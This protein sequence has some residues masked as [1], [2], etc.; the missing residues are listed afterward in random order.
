MRLP[1]CSLTCL[2]LVPPS[3][4]GEVQ[5][6]SIVLRPRHYVHPQN[7]TDFFCGLQPELDAGRLLAELSSPYILQ[8]LDNTEDPD[9]RYRTTVQD[10]AFLT[11][12]SA[13]HMT[14]SPCNASCNALFALLL[15]PPTGTCYTGVFSDAEILGKDHIVLSSE[16][17]G[18]L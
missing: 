5:H 15:V 10:I 18:I 12:T 6:I 17:A 7:R 13:I 1:V 8:L 2:L 14:P 9:T 4:L 3:C 16:Q 11:P